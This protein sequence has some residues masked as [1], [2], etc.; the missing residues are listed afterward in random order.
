MAAIALVLLAQVGFEAL[1]EF[2][3]I[4]AVSPGNGPLDPSP[5]GILLILF[6]P[7]ARADSLLI[8][9]PFFAA[10][11]AFLG[12]IMIVWWGSPVFVTPTKLS[13]NAMY[14]QA[15]YV[16]QAFIIGY[17]PWIMAFGIVR[18]YL[19][20]DAKVSILLT[21]ITI[22]LLTI[23]LAYVW[24]HRTGETP[25]P[26]NV[27][28]AFYAHWALLSFVFWLPVFVLSHTHVPT[29]ISVLIGAVVNLVFLAP[30]IPPVVTKLQMV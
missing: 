20:E 17:L 1:H 18:F 21:W 26:S 13:W 3:A 2:Q 6:G 7:H 11:G 15:K 30:G 8:T 25:L 9:F 23:L 27:E 10:V 24:N 19:G 16:T 22:H 29:Q 14:A 28:T 4:Y 5:A 12:Y